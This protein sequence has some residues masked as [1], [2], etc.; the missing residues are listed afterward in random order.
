MFRA[1]IIG[2]GLL[3]A[4]GAPQP[5]EAADLTI[6]WTRGFY[7]AQ[8]EGITQVAEQFQKDT[9]TTV[10]LE[11]YS[12]KDIPLKLQ[13]ALEAGQPPDV[14]DG[15]SGYSPHLKQW[16][17]EGRFV[18]LGDI[19]EPLTKSIDP[20][21]LK[22]AYLENKSTGKWAYYSVPIE[23]A[24][25]HI[26]VWRSLLEQARIRIDQIPHEWTPF[27]A[28]FCE[29][30]Q[31]AIRNATGKREVYGIGLPSSTVANDTRQS[32]QGFC[33]PTMPGSWTKM[34]GS[35]SI[36]QVCGS[37]LSKLSTISRA[38]RR[39]AATRLARSVGAMWTTM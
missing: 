18:D 33:S 17:L 19:V 34:A 15:A 23:T 5:L 26:H 9:G 24:S 28:F 32:F 1:S 7:P 27:W 21:L 8:D 14:S 16:A 2:T 35:C 29:T 20:A 38:P 4:V 10:D 37:A 31:P 11:F 13:A 30:V 3:L 39:Q 12:N 22:T 25:I 36:S 6:W